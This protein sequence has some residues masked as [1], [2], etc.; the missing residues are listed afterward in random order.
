MEIRWKNRLKDGLLLGFTASVAE[1]KCRSTHRYKRLQV[2][3]VLVRNAGEEKKKKNHKQGS[4]VILKEYGK[5][6]KLWRIP[7]SH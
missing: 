3:K 4:L 5:E 7:H 2:E 1:V 6:L